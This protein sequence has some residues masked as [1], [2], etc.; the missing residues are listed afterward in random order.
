MRTVF[1]NPSRRRRRRRAHKRANP[2]RRRHRRNSAVALTSNPRRRRRVRRR[3]RNAG[4]TPFVSNPQILSNPR[5]RRRRR[6][7]SA[8]ILS[9]LAY[10]LGGTVGGAALNRLAFNTINNFYVRNGARVASAA[11]L[12]YIGGRNT[13]TAAAAGAT[14]APLIPDLELLISHSSTP[15]AT[16][17]PRELAAELSAL[18]EADLS[19]GDELSD[20]DLSDDQLEADLS[21]DLIDDDLIDD[22]LEDIA[23]MKW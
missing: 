10:I 21:D 4:V 5:R 2:R 22:D 8:T 20:D 9:D 6:N 16:K 11:L 17:N 14:L 15:T 18:L 13:L 23:D 1:V 3:R 7:P 12:A 19:D